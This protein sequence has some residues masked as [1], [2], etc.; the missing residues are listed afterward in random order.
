[1][2]LRYLTEKVLPVLQQKAGDSLLKEMVKVFTVFSRKLV[3]V[4]FNRDGG[5]MK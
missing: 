5:I 4:Y 1:M 2:F 3:N